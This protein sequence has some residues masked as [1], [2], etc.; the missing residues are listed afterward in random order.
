MFESLTLS[1]FKAF[2]QQ[3]IGLRPLTML[4][5]LNGMGKSSILQSLLLLR[6]SYQQR[7]LATDTGIGLVLNGELV[8]LGTG[9][10]ILFDSAEQD[11][12]GFALKLDGQDA[13]WRFAYDRQAD[14]LRHLPES[15][16]LPSFYAS[17]L[18]TDNFHY[19]E[20]ERVGPRTSFDMADF[21]VREHRQMGTK[22]QYA[23]HFLELFRSSEVQEKLHHPEGRSSILVDQVT[24]WMGDISPGAVIRVEGYDDMDLMRLAFGFERADTAGDVRYYR[25]TNVGFGLTYTMPVLVALLSSPPGSLVLLEN[26]EAHLHPRGQS[27][28]GELIARAADV[29]I[30]VLVETHSDHIL[31]GIRVAVKRGLARPEDIAMHFF[32]LPADGSEL[33]GIEVISPQI[34]RDGRL[35]V[36]PD[37]FF[38]EY[39]KSLRNLL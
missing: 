26:P 17:N 24:A 30:Q 36:W 13:H 33:S 10:D 5:G 9:H 20:A 32:Q 38:D 16:V 25:S 31:N 15:D 18:F 34:D 37:N 7:A 35:D 29:G 12:I 8:Q 3:Q 1:N 21:V 4:A 19:L 22:G 39:G 23:A 6:Q 28:I 14:V 11:E 27:K 2:K